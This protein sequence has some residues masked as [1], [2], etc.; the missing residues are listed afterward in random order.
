MPRIRALTDNT[1]RTAILVNKKKTTRF[2]SNLYTFQFPIPASRR[3]RK[4]PG[5]IK[6]HG[7]FRISPYNFSGFF[8]HGIIQKIGGKPNRDKHLVALDPGGRQ[9]NIPNGNVFEAIE[10][11]LLFKVSKMLLIFL[12]QLIP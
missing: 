4:G 1:S 6:F 10:S 11:A 5:L 8:I 2:I 7:I 12:P 9:F 3:S